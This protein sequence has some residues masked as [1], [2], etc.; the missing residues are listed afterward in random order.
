MTIALRFVN[1]TVDDIDAAVAFYRDALGFEVRNTVEYGPHRWVTLGSP[2]E[3]AEL[4]LSE[5]HA[6]RSQEDGD[7]LQE[8]LVKGMLPN[9]IFKADDVDAAFARVRASGAEIVQ[10]P[11]DQDWGPRDCAFR[12][13]A[14][15]ILRLAAA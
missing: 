14:G 9:L 11:M 6:G 13:P 10:E 7:A 3:A 5:P 12:D 4:V 15:N 1:I 8:L 2:D